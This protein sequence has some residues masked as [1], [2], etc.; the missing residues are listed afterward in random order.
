[1]K[2]TTGWY[3]IAPPPVYGVLKTELV[4]QLK[5]RLNKVGSEGVFSID[6]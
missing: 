3:D 5:R 2:A 1:M 4:T 6:I